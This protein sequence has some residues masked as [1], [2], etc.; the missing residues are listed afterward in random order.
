VR[1][2]EQHGIEFCCGGQVALDEA[3]RGRGLDPGALLAEIE[4]EAAPEAGG[5]EWST[6]PLA[7]LIDHILSAH[8]AYL[9]AELPRLAAALE[10]IEANHGG[11]YREIPALAPV[12][13]ALHGELEGH[14]LKEERVLFPLIRGM[15]AAR[16]EGRP[17]APAHCGS[18][19]N[20]V[21]MMC[22]EHDSAGA[23]LA[24]MRSL[25][26]GYAVPDGA[27][28]TLR[29]FYYELAVLERD[30]HRHIHLENNILFP[31]AIALE[32]GR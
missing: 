1:I 25:T 13:R 22:M 14:L 5:R 15:E 7:D 26:A 31:R 30:L 6:A 20:P 21:R 3:C 19:R 4:Q 11:K 28:N 32:E 23:A 8:H 17:F 9:K 2:F 27:C 18:V 10:K 12:F 24:G 29:A 16:A